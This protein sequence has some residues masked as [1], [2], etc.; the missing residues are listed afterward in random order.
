MWQDSLFWM[1]HLFLEYKFSLLDEVSIELSEP[2]EG[3]EPREK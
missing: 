3:V 2:L 1:L